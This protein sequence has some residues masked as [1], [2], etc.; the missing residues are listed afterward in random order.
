MGIW[1]M[2]TQTQSMT[3]LGYIIN[4]VLIQNSF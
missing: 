3:F 2:E 4:F 1:D